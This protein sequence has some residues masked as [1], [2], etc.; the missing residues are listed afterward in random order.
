MIAANTPER[1]VSITQNN[2]EKI[3]KGRNSNTTKTQPSTVREVI[4]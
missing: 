1:G 3:S 2:E 4:R